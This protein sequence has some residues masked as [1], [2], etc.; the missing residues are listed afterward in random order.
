MG[1]FQKLED[2]PSSYIC[3]VLY[4]EHS[5]CLKQSLILNGQYND[6]VQFKSTGGDCIYSLFCC[7]LGLTLFLS[8][9]A[10]PSELA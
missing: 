9:F 10:T 2:R 4:E 5:S 1:K 7:K 3:K 8:D 6:F